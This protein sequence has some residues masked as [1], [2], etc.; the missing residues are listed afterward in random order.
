MYCIRTSHKSEID[1]NIKR[2][3]NLLTD[4]HIEF[5]LMLQPASFKFIDGVS[6]RT[7]IGFLAQ[8][9]EEAMTACGLTSLDFA[10]FCKDVK[11]KSHIDEEGNEIEEP[12]L[13]ENGNATYIY[14]LRY[15]EFVALI[16]HCVRYLFQQLKKV[17][18]QNRRIYSHKR[19]TCGRLRNVS[20]KERM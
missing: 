13:D 2:D 14:S 15:E 12:I 17:N 18:K 1:K 8:Q 3:I 6:N 10:G 7:H 4:K 9:V 16:T 20:K 5:F 11:V 19:K